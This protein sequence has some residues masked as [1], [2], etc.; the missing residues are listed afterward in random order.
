MCELVYDTKFI[1][2]ANGDLLSRRINTVFH[3]RLEAIELFTSGAMGARQN[4]RL[5][6]EYSGK[7]REHR[8]EIIRLFFQAI[9]DRGIPGRN[10]LSSSE[11]ERV[12]KAWSV[13][14]KHVLAAAI[15]GHKPRIYT[16]EQRLNVDPKRIHREFGITVIRI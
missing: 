9:I 4:G 14:D 13:H 3:R 7:I 11:W 8:N 2:S 1:A 15:D 10:S 6:Y 12:K 16:T 5:L